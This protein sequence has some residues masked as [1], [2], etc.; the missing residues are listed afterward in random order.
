MVEDASAVFA[1][2]WTS[3]LPAHVFEGV[4]LEPEF[5]CSLGRGEQLLSSPV[6]HVVSRVNGTGQKFREKLVPGECRT[7]RGCRDTPVCVRAGE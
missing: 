6:G 5:F 1:E 2:R 3:A 4:L 7:S